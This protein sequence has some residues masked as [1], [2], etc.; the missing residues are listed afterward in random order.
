MVLRSYD[1]VEMSAVRSL[2]DKA[3]GTNHQFQVRILATVMTFQI[4]VGVWLL[5]NQFSLSTNKGAEEAKERRRQ[6]NN[7]KTVSINWNN[8]RAIDGQREGFEELICQLAAQEKIDKQ[9]QFFRI[10]KPDAGKECY[11]ELSTGKIQSWQA[12]YFVNSLSDSQWAQLSE[13]VKKAIDNHP[14]LEKYYVAIPVDRPDGKT[15]GKSMLQ[16]WKE[17]VAEW[18]KYAS[19][20]KMKVTFE[21]WGKHELETRLRQRKNEGL[22]YYFFNGLI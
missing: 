2:M 21:Y 14:N 16:K 20:K 3:I 13:S 6:K 15:R 12:K 5:P 9:V 17:Y 19:S 4:Y 10:G 18:E 22:M 1:T 11:W 7:K 8:I